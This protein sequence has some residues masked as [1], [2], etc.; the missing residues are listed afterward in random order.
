MLLLAGLSA[1]AQR[2]TNFS[3]PTTMCAGDIDTVSFGYLSSHN[4]VIHNLVTT[5]GH[6]E[7]IFLPDGVPCGTM[8]CSYRSPVTFQDFNPNAT[9]TSVN[10][11]NYVRLNIEHSY[12]GDIYINIT[13]PNGQKAD[14]MRFGGRNTSSC[15]GSIPSTSRGW[16]DGNNVMGYTYF[17]LAH[18]YS[19]STYKCDSSANGNSP[20]VGWSYCWSSNTSNGYSYA[21]TSYNDDGIIYRS[22]HSHNGIID[23]SNVAAHTNFYHPDQNLSSLI[24]CPLNGTWYIEV[25]DG[26]SQ[27]NGYIFEWELALNE[28]LVNFD[29]CNVL[30]Y[31]IEGPGV[32][33]LTDSTFTITAPENLTHDSTVLYTYRVNTTCGTLDSNVYLT[34]HPTYYSNLDTVVCEQFV[35]RG[36]TYTFSSTFTNNTRTRY[37]CDSI[38]RMSVVV[39]PGYHLQQT[40]DIVENNLPYTFMGLDFDGP[41]T[42]S[43]FADT[44]AM[45]CDS[46]MSFTLVVYPNVSTEVYD[47]IC[48]SL[49]PYSWNGQTLR[50]EGDASV[51]LLTTHGADSTVTM[52]LTVYNPK[53]TTLVTEVVENDLPVTFLGFP[54]DDSFDTTLFFPDIHGCDSAV[55]QQLVVYRNHAY[56]YRRSV[57]D[58]Q[59]PFTWDGHTFIQADSITFTLPD[60]HGAD[61]T[62]TLVLTV[63]PIYSVTVDT[64]VCDNKPLSIDGRELRTSGTHNIV[65]RTADGCDSSITVNLTVN[66]HHEISLHDTICANSYYTFG[67]NTYSHSGIYIYSTTN[68]YGCDSIVTLNLSIVA[69]N[70]KASIRAIPTMVTPNDPDFNLYDCSANSTSRQWLIGATTST[71]RNLEYSYPQEADSLPIQLIAYSPEGCADTAYTLILIDR[72][73]M[74][75]PNVFTPGQEQNNTWQPAFM[76]IEYLEFWIYNRQGLLVSHQEGIDSRWDGSHN[77]QPCPQGSYVFNLKY[78]SQKRPNN[79]Q[80]LTGTILLLR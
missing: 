69:G 3:V 77:G 57:C 11:I 1:E 17:G 56:T 18:D 72:S 73:T 71:E 74:F 2:I 67:D 50:E 9:I 12:I 64:T 6:S 47:S 58:N 41:V 60:C 63:T 39:L 36:N 28:D 44:T 33:I 5:L 35:W 70:L 25:V 52:H 68:E 13:C 7:R 26:Y 43:L 51:T 46:N 62:V 38:D 31:E 37:G 20:G 29:T 76:D 21:H 10:D 78:R 80:S 79:L 16:L 61:S 55:N 75:L 15:Y 22:G 19:N 4:V 65:L 14:I 45:G 48:P 42:D 24:G 49:L 54:R 30:T 32:T 27:D 59:I 8:G 40:V 53:D 66:P 34:F 23:S